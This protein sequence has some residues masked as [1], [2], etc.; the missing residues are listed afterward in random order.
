MNTS[1]FAFKNAGEYERS[2]TAEFENR[3][4]DQVVEG[5]EV[6]IPDCM[7]R[8]RARELMS[9]FASQLAQQGIN[10]DDFMRFSGEKADKMLES[11]RPRAEQQ[12]KSRL[13][14]E[15]VALAEGIEIGEEEINEKYKQLSEQYK[16]EVEKLKGIIPEKELVR[17]LLC[18]RAIDIVKDNAVALGSGS[19]CAEE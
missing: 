15:A 18:N 19:R 9:E 13:A 7:V 16:V 17:D 6:D 8:D 2:S 11:F 4:I 5:I 1:R 12:V 3:L 14:M 10:M